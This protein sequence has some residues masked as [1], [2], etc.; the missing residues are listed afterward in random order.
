M[1]IADVPVV[2]AGQLA[3]DRIPF[4]AIRIA[5]AALFAALGVWVLFAGVPG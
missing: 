3:A 2:F 4:K 5:A 1:L